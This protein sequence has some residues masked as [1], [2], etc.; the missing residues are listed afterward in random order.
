M[1]YRLS[2]LIAAGAREPRTVIDY[3]PT[4]EL[5]LRPYFACKTVDD[6]KSADEKYRIWQWECW[7][8]SPGLTTPIHQTI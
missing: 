2:H 8:T 4:A 6:I 1:K 5:C 7:A 3:A